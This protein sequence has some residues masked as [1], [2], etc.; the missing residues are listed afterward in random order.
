MQVRGKISL[1]PHHAGIQGRPGLL[2]KLYKE[3]LIDPDFAIQDR[4][5]MNAKVLAD[6]AGAWWGFAGSDLG[7]FMTQ[8]AG[9]EPKSFNLSGAP[10]PI[11]PAKK[12]YSFESAPVR[13]VSGYG[14]AITTA[15]KHPAEAMKWIDYAYSKEG[16]LLYN[17]G[18]EGLTYNMVNGYPKYTDLIMKN[19]DGLP[20]A[21]AMAKHIL[22][23][24]NWALV[25]DIRYFEQFQ[26]ALAMKA[27]GVWTKAERDRVVPPLSLSAAES[28]AISSKLNEINTYAEEMYIKFIIGTVPLSDFDKFVS[29]IKQLGIDEV[30][31]VYQAALER[32]GKRK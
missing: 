32:Y 30:V 29:T 6:Q 19:P 9:K 12:P 14:L 16:N 8:M 2:N 27:I 3:G 10:Y 4:K 28:Q 11:G 13:P 20:V 22:G 1:Q 7:T 26:S 15:C 21:T 23:S 25:Q 5:Q 24:Q 18:V 31:K 17:F